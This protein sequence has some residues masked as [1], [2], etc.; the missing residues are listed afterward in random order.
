MM[1]GHDPVDT[2]L[3]ELASVS[4]EEFYQ[5]E[6]L[7]EQLLKE[8]VEV[9]SHPVYSKHMMKNTLIVTA[10]D[11]AIRFR[12]NMLEYLHDVRGDFPLDD[13]GVDLINLGETLTRMVTKRENVA[14]TSFLREFRAGNTMNML[15][16]TDF[17]ELEA[18]HRKDE[19]FQ[20][21]IFWK[22]GT[23]VGLIEKESVN[24]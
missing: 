13:F 1:K 24:W 5:E 9:P 16:Y 14:L 19:D 21:A 18:W 3:M 11:L 22:D 15:S 17:D 2:T 10:E 23:P 20:I 8:G 4:P 7:K 6:E 12:D